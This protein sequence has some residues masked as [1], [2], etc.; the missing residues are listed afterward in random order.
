MFSNKPEPQQRNVITNDLFGLYVH[1]PFC[2]SKCPYCDFNSHVRESIDHKDWEEAYIKELGYAAQRVAGK[3]L[4]S[5]FFGGGTPSL[6][7]PSTVERIISEA[8]KIWNFAPDIEITLEANPT[9]VEK[10]KFQGFKAAGVNRVSLGVQSLND[11]ALKFLGRTHSALEARAAIE[12]AASVFDR[13]S[14]DLIYARPEQA[15][16]QWHAE[17]SQALT[18]ADAHMSLYQLTIEPGTRFFT[19]HA[20]G[21]F[22]MPQQD[23]A[24]GMYE[25]TQQIMSDAG[26]PAYEVSNH[27]RQGEASR[28]N[29]AY[30][31]YADY[32]GIGPGAHGRVSHDGQKYATRTHRAPEIWMQLV[33]DNGHGYHEWELIEHRDRFIE[34][35]MMGLR[36]HEG[37]DLARLSYECEDHWSAMID[38]KKL[39][40]LEEE[41]LMILDHEAQN[42]K[43][44]N[45]GIQRLNSLL[46][47]L[48]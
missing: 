44:T 48:L 45:A 47:F 11:E 6:M 43:A 26:L 3:T 15:E 16:N 21:A 38:L 46:S 17:L 5:I 28:H 42:L 33:N 4:T 36:L 34:A 31:R 14:F 10:D 37:V 19:E 30:W 8:S 23:E 18:I 9:S 24:G 1:W 29:L 20:R 40:T 12:V 7:Q 25:M 13:T 27:A 22:K 32:V 35:L 41:G 39:E 2:A